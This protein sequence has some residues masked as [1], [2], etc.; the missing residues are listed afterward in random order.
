MAANSVAVR[1]FGQDYSISGSLPRDE[2]MKL[3]DYVDIK[4]K[5]IGEGYKG[6]KTDVAVLAAMTICEELFVNYSVKDE[7]SAA[8]ARVDQLSGQLEESQKLNKELYGRVD[9]LTAQLEKTKIVPPESQKL[10]NDLEAKCRDVESSFFDI[11][12]ENIHLK[13]ELEAIRRQGR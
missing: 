9:E 1:I 3:A 8:L 4:M 10:I 6:P 11:Q 7:L 2:I 13:N 12:M 5:E